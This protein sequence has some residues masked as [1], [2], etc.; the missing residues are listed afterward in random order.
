MAAL[1]ETGQRTGFRF[2]GDSPATL[3][4]L[5]MSGNQEQLASAGP[6]MALLRRRFLA[7]EYFLARGKEE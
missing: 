7:T 4:L 5:N 3:P 6:A 2:A 1:A